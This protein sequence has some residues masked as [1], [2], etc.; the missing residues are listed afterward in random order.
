MYRS[1]QFIRSYLGFVHYSSSST[2]AI[3][4]SVGRRGGNADAS[5]TD[6]AMIYS[7][8]FVSQSPNTALRI[9]CSVNLISNTVTLTKCS[10]CTTPHISVIVNPLC[11][12]DFQISSSVTIHVLIFAVHAWYL[13]VHT[14]IFAVRVLSK[15]FHEIFLTV[16]ELL[17]AV[18]VLLFVVL[19]RFK[20]V[21]AH[22]LM[23]LILFLAVHAF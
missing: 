12:H 8:I 11:K 20:P 13:T 6:H 10:K 14:L 22:L 5:F 18:H 19:K 9:S 17:L 15:T 4:R 2:Y 16:Y 21:H 1:T 23:V 7:A 3:T